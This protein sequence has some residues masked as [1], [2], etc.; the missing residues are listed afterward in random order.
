MVSGE[1]LRL[2]LEIS[3]G[4]DLDIFLEAS[5]KDI[6]LGTFADDNKDKCTL[7]VVGRNQSVGLEKRVKPFNIVSGEF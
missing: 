3:V 4:S 5:L 2:I 7:N 6:T 1:S